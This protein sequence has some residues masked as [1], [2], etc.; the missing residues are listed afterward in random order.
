MNLYISRIPK[1]TD[2]ITYDLYTVRKYIRDMLFEKKELRQGW[3]FS[4]YDLRVDK[5]TWVQQAM[6]NPM[7]S[8]TQST[9]IRKYAEKRFSILNPMCSI[10][11][12]DIIIIP[13]VDKNLLDNTT[14]F[15]IVTATSIYD[16]EDRSSFD[17]GYEKDFG[18]LIKIDNI[19]CFSRSDFYINFGSYQ[20]AFNRV[21]QQEIKNLISE[22][23]LEK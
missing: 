13:N 23:Y 5:E 4:T 8:G 9:G 21:H 11:V 19:K 12:G 18:H 10:E 17:K 6:K 20:K 2:W 16:F 15:T 3:G 1:K 22:Y 14:V 7:G